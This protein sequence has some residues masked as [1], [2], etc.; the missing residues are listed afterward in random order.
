MEPGFGIFGDNLKCIPIIIYDGQTEG[1]KHYGHM[2]N[3]VMAYIPYYNLE[4]LH[5]ANGDLS[6]VEYEQN[7]LKKVP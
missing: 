2:R 3:D 1:D 4:R 5:T 7:S 6:P